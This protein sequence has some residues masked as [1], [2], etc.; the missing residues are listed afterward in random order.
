MKQGGLRLELSAETL[1]RLL[2]RG[3]LCAA[4]LH[5][6]DCDSKH[7]L[8]RLL[9]MSCSKTM[10]TA[11][12]CD[13]CCEKCGNTKPETLNKGTPSVTDSTAVKSHPLLSSYQITIAHFLNNK[14]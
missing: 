10:N 6:L 2:E 12:G 5:C 3:E 8:W 9:L 1:L 4:E 14:R 7:C 13:G 11:R